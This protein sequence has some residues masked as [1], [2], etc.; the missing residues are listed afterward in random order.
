MHLTTFAPP[1]AHRAHR[2]PRLQRLIGAALIAR[3]SLLVTA[4]ALVSAAYLVSTGHGDN[5]VLAWIAAAA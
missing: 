5:L 4:I 2:S 1:R 3:P